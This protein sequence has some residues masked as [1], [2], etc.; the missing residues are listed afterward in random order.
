MRADTALPKSTRSWEGLHVMRAFPRSSEAVVRARR[1]SQFL[2]RSFQDSHNDAR[3]RLAYNFKFRRQAG[4]SS[5]IAA[6]QEWGVLAGADVSLGDRTSSAVRFQYSHIE[7][8]EEEAVIHLFRHPT[9]PR[10]FNFNQIKHL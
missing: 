4:P 7:Q 10:Q 1:Q 3:R 5:V 8:I 6:L 9:N 2:R